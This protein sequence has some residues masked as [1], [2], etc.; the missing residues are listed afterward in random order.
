[1]V[2]VVVESGKTFDATEFRSF[3]DATMPRFAVPAYVR[4]VD[5]LPKTPSQRIQKFKLR[6]EGITADTVDIRPARAPKTKR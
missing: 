3:C 5:E 2:A 1:M 4:V 6:A